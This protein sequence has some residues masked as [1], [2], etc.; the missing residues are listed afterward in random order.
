MWLAITHPEILGR[1]CEVCEKTVFDD[2]PDRLTAR[3]VI[4]RATSL[5]L[6]RP[7]GSPLPC[8]ICPRTAQA[9]DRIRANAISMSEKNWQA[10]Q[11][12]KE[13]KAVGEF[14]NDPI[15]RRNAAIIREVEDHCERR[16]RSQISEILA[17][18]ARRK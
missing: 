11:H 6:V 5:P 16:D 14:P 17:A 18:L 13:C 3:P 10:W 7:A 15:V 4:D 2:Q 8:R 1:S 9:E 12:Y